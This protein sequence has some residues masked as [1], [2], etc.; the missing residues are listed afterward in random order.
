MR[1]SRRESHRLGRFRIYRGGSTRVKQRRPLWVAAAVV[2]WLAPAAA[3]EGRL[4]LTDVTR[5]AG[6][7]FVHVSGISEEKRLPETD[8]S[9]VAVLDVD[10]DGRLDLYF[11]NSGHLTDGRAGADNALFRGRGDGT[12]ERDADAGGAP[13]AAYGMGVL[14]GDPDNDGDPDL[15]LTAWGADQFY[16]NDG[17]RFA[18][19]TAAAGLGNTE[20][21]SSAAWLDHDNDGDLDLI[22]VNYVVFD[23]ASHPWCGRRDMDMR[24]Y[25]DPRQ[26]EATRDL[27]YRNDGEAGFVEV[28]EDA[29]IDL[30]GNGLG[31]I[32][33]DFDAD[34]WM[35]IYVANDMT[36]NFHYRNNGDGTFGEEGML[37]GTAL[38]ADG[39]SQAG[40]GVDAADYDRDG[41]L[42]L[43]VTNYQLEN[44]ALYRNDG[45][46][47]TDASFAAGIGEVSLNYLGFGIGFFDIDNDAW[48]D[49]F[50]ANG[51]VHDNIEQYDPLVTYAQRAQLLVNRGGRYIDVTDSLGAALAEA[52]YVGRGS[53]FGDIDDDGDVDVVMTT[54]NGPAHL[55]RNDSRVG[56]WLRVRLRGRESNR[57]AI[58]AVVEVHTGAE[59]QTFPVLGGRSYQSSSEAT[60]HA[61]LAT[62][63]TADSVVVRWP[64][65]R[66]STHGPFEARTTIELSEPGS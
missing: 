40:M 13:G 3:D 22:V 2:A 33:A 34:G 26:Y 25:C 43:V 44:N 1:E 29:G 51:H 6:I 12:F 23:P 7:D 62:A 36:P 31:V 66:R 55:L 63:T 50:V 35:D 38:S 39:A 21:G 57:D 20:W 61:G 28:G 59:R 52:T 27:L 53:A 5:D 32:A 54:S 42:D 9:G 8:G 48:L 24:F 49:L 37:S 65:G 41:D 45:S 17:G 47:F 30:P 15:Y 18:D 14:A 58:G 56:G 19:A 46:Y 11:A 4:R 16:R 10:G 64:S 60:V